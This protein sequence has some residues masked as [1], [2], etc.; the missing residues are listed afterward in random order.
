[1]VGSDARPTDAP[2]VEIGPEAAEGATGDVDDEQ[3]PARRLAATTPASANDFNMGALLQR[4]PAARAGLVGSDG[5]GVMSRS[6]P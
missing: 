5:H 4:D 6:C 3:A 2:S 1:M